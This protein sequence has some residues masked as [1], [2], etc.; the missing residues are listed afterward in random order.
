MTKGDKVK[1]EFVRGTTWRLIIYQDNAV[2][3]IEEFPATYA[4]A[5][6]MN[7]MYWSEYPLECNWPVH[8]N[9]AKLMNKRVLYAMLAYP[10]ERSV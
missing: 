4:M 2:C 8:K 1:I 3:D 7:R 6:F 10:H 9:D 5:P